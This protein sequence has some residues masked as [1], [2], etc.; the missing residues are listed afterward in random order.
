[1]AD[2]YLPC[3]FCGE[4]HQRIDARLVGEPYDDAL[5][6]VFR[7]RCE[8]GISTPFKATA[9]EVSDLWHTRDGMHCEPS[10]SAQG[11]I[12]IPAGYNEA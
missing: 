3:P 8:C 10:E 2:T 1:M 5:E 11:L 9:T 6:K 7:I 4:D 12:P